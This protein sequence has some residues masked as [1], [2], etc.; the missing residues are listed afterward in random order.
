[1][2]ISPRTGR[3]SRRRAV[4]ERFLDRVLRRGYPPGRLAGRPAGPNVHP[5]ETPAEQRNPPHTSGNGV[6]AA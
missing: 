5:P 3:L 1:M 6:S 2:N 4:P